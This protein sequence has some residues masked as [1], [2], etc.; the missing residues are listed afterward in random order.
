MSL[1]HLVIAI[2]SVI[3]F[4]LMRFLGC[5]ASQFVKPQRN[6]IP[7]IK[8]KILTTP[9]IELSRKIKKGDLTSEQV[10]RC[11]IKRIE[12][13]NPII[14]AVVDNRFNLAIEE[15]KE[16]DTN[17]KRARDGSG[18]S[19]IL[20]LPLLGVPITIKENV[21]L[22]GASLTCGLK[23]WSSRKADRDSPVVKLIR[24]AGLIPLAT[25]NTPTLCLWWDAS[26]PVHG[27]TNNPY[28]LS[29]I[30]GG[31]SGGEGAILAA[32]GSV[33]GFGNDVAGSIRIPAN[34]CGVFGHKP[35]PFVVTNEGLFPSPRHERG[36]VLCSGP[37][38]RHACD[39]LPML[40]VMAGTEV[41][42][43][44]LGEPVDLSKLKVYYV[45]E[46]GDPLAANCNVEILKKLR[47]AVAHLVQKFKA[48][49][50]KVT[51]NELKYGFTLWSAEINLYP[52]LKAE[53]ND[54]DTPREMN[55]Y[56]E[57]VKK[58]FNR[59]DYDFNAIYATA[60]RKSGPNNDTATEILN[61]RAETLRKVF[62]DLVGE[63]GV[64]LMATHPEPAPG[65]YTTPFKVFNVSYTAA[66]SVLQTP[67]TQCPLGLSKDGLPIGIQILARPHNDKLTIAVAQE[68]E[69]AFGGWMP[70]T[71]VLTT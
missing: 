12:E 37:M 13:V 19:A 69:S 39:L 1:H 10:I 58:M 36:R 57:L 23:Y 26:N 30:S 50:E 21:L 20:D 56:L 3:V 55:P 47:D 60:L 46:T 54:P 64:L 17:I 43:L 66:T 41:D 38:T 24:K 18:D 51:L 14:N 25:T 63:T 70:P 5:I 6:A 16:I 44:K 2:R 35:T 61:K 29:R 71:R 32:G 42:S 7:P 27:R 62:N 4:N 68:L 22:K 53:P 40:K 15:A 8:D 31:S 34:F 49:V 48:P 9:A 59:S 45:E 67:I 65:H 52:P 28:D 11:Y 33:V